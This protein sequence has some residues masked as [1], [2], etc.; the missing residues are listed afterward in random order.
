MPASQ[1]RHERVEIVD[2][3]VTADVGAPK[4]ELAAGPQHVPE[5]PRRV[6]PQGRAGARRLEPAPVPE[7]D[8]EGAV[9]ERAA[10]LGAKPLRAPGVHAG[11]I[12]PLFA[13]DG[14][15]LWAPDEVSVIAVT[16]QTHIRSYLVCTMSTRAL[17][18]SVHGVLEILAAP[19]IMVAPFLLDFGQAAT[20]IS[21]MLGVVLLG[22]AL[23]LE[24]PSRSVPLSAHAGFDYGLALVALIG[25]LA[26]GL[27]TDEWSAGIFLVGV[28]VAL[29]ALT[30]STRFTAPRGA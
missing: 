1:Q 28:G 9:R 3:E 11:E 16:Q 7:L 30:A 15:V 4:S 8:R 24:G 5:C 29:M 2:V 13:N 20:V 17:S 23:Q 10:E 27:G 25:G 12:T 19:A 26:V 14:V 18:V 6:Q 22:L 21:V